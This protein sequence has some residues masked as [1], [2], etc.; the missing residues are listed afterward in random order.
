MN[1]ALVILAAGKGKRMKSDLPKVL[2]PILGKPMIDWVYS[3]SE[4][5]AP[6][7]IVAIV[8]YGADQVRTALNDRKVVFALQKKQLGTGHA[9]LCAEKALS[10]YKGNIMI[11]N[12]DFPLIS[13]NTLKRFL[14]TH[15]KTRSAVTVLTSK[16]ENPTSY[17]RVIRGR[18]GELEKIVEH[19]DA[20]A[21]E[22]KVDEINTGAYCVKSEVLWSA[23]KNLKRNNRQ[24]EYY[25]TD[26]IAY[27]KNKGLR[28][29]GY[30]AKN[31]KEVIG[32]NDRADLALAE[33]T[34]R[35]W[36]NDKLMASGVTIIDPESTYISP[37][38]KVA[39]DTT[40]YPNTYIYGSSVVGTG[41]KIGPSVWLE[42]CA[43][44]RDVWVKFSCYITNAK[45]KDSVTVG[46][47]AHIRPE[48]EIL[49]NAKIGNFVEIKKS[50]IGKG[51]KVP[52]LSY[53]GDAYLGESVNIGAGTITCN[54]DGVNKH[55]TTIGDNVFIGSDTM[56]VAPIT[57]GAGAVTGAG[58]T[59]TKDVP[60]G[61]LAIARA[62]QTVIEQWKQ[63]T[64][65]P[66]GKR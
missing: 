35:H 39:R 40:I 25:L 46:P 38:A 65:K 7:K 37:D 50:T 19:G 14:D 8:G 11:L 29:S 42:D 32:V 61:A 53:V 30:I 48:A 2:H 20:T 21:Q 34:M 60:G 49:S 9:V 64:R 12:G 28:L 44:G 26:I 63:K 24:S 18:G 4:K 22:K 62:R 57:V 43:L 66:K 45:I 5:L 36:V 17:G 54:Y 15:A 58:S 13:S 6:K 23:L 1:F 10:G 51:S 55:R 56:L 47:F 33:Q 27:A 59:I 31:E 3:A 52:H 41:S 16:F